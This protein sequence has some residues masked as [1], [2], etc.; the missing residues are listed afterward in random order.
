MLESTYADSDQQGRPAVSFRLDAEGS[1]RFGRLTGRNLPNQATGLKKY[2][3]ILLNRQLL[4]APTI[5]S[6]ITDQGIIEGDFTQEEVESL[7]NVLNAGRLPAA[8]NPT[9][10]SEKVISPTLGAATVRQG[11]IAIVVSMALVLVFMLF[12]YRFAGLVACLALISNLMLVL[13]TMVLLKADFT[14][15]GLAGLVLTIGMSVDANVLIFER[16]REELARGAAFRMAIRNGFDKAK[17]AIYDANV[18]TLLTGIVLFWIGTD[19]IKGFATTLIIG[20]IMSVYTAVFCS[21]IIFDV[22]ERRGWKRELKM[23]QIVGGT[24]IDFLSMRYPAIIASCVLIAIGVLAVVQ[25]GTDMLNIDFMGGVSA[26][27]V[28]QEDSELSQGEI[29]D[30]LAKTDLGDRNLLVVEE[31][32]IDID[33]TAD[34]RRFMVYAHVDAAEI[35]ATDPDGSPMSEVDYVQDILKRTFREDLATYAVE[36]AELSA[37]PETEP[38]AF[39][40]GTEARI[41]FNEAVSFS[42]IETQLES[43]LPQE[44]DGRALLFNLN[45]EGYAPG[46]AERFTAWDVEINVPPDAARPLLDQFESQMDGSPLFPMANVIHGQVASDMQK[47][48][49]L[50]IFFSLLCIIGYIWLRF[51]QVMFGL[52]AVIAVVHDVLVAIGLLAVSA[53]LVNYIPPL[54]SALQLE[55]FQISLQ[56]VAALLTIIGYSLNDTIVI[57]DR[58]REVRGKSPNLTKEMINTSVNQTLSR[59]LL[60][61]FTTLIVVGILYFFG[62]AGIHAFAFALVVGVIAGTYSTVFIASP[63]LLWMSRPA[64]E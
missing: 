20:I 34:Q 24:N 7:V 9:P 8:L 2:L 19:E 4:S 36:I 10:L 55:P 53:W 11:A 33:E 42:S 48:A 64:P 38:G 1:T 49:A 41:V 57:F 63:A 58:I 27:M 45:T 23:M 30:M 12:Y 25:R 44:V 22:A 21:R 15:P 35:A 43:V 14:L 60:T 18:T 28:L 54:A 56:V 47:L 6:R 29:R 17:S 62:G 32:D 13:A 39:A 61:S 16:I 26:S 50:A 46:S 5:N 37:I 3:G 59:T 51:Q 31:Q 52:A 40:G